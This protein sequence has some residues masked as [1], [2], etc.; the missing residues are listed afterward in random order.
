M[1]DIF[2]GVNIDHIATLRN[3][4]GENDPALLEMVHEV[5]E[6]GADSLTMHLREDRRHI[7]DADIFE[8]KKHSKIPINFEMAI[9]NEMVNIALELKPTSVCLVPEK[10]EE[11]TTEGGLDISSHFER[12]QTI[13]PT[14]QK[15]EIEVYLFV[16]P[17]KADIEQSTKL[18]VKGVELHTGKYARSFVNRYQRQEQIQLL[19]QAAQ[20]CKEFSLECHAGHGL[21]YH[22]ITDI[23]F[24]E[25]LTEVNIGHAIIARS[26][27][28]GLRAAVEEMKFLLQR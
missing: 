18:N 8:I 24:L 17:T 28:A 5:I 25:N 3:A 7:Q 22:N 4:R 23:L 10:R 6:G 11:Q 27:K 26:L 20:T 2:L 13:I 19:G 15:E 16:E 14:L 12:L 21:N 1:K 9:T